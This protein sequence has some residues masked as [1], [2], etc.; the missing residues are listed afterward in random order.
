[1]IVVGID[2]TGAFSDEGMWR[3]TE[4]QIRRGF[5]R[6]LT[7]EAEAKSKIVVYKEGVKVHG[8]DSISRAKE[9]VDIV[10]IRMLFE[11]GDTVFL[12]G[13]SRGGAIAI[14]AARQLNNHSISVTGLVLFDAVSRVAD[15]SETFDAEAI[16]ENVKIAVHAYRDPSVRSQPVFGNCGMRAANPRKTHFTLRSFRATHSGMGGLP[17]EGDFP[18]TPSQGPPK[19]YERSSQFVQAKVGIPE[20]DG[21][22]TITKAEDEAGSRAVEMFMWHAMRQMG[23]L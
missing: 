15:I 8:G 13:Y 1:M 10:K 12:A 7:R 19:G 22:P 14:D 21:V 5:V 20:P 6:R 2:G 23:M 18:S 4:G 16:S 11:P 17:W 3:W 9:V